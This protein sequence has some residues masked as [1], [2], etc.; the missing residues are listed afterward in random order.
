MVELKEVWAAS[1]FHSM[2][3]ETSAIFIPTF[4]FIIYAD[5]RMV[6]DLGYEDSFT[7]V[8]N[9][10]LMLQMMLELFAELSVDS[11]CT[12]V[13]LKNDIDVLGA[14]GK[15]DHPVFLVGWAG[16]ML[17]SS[18]F[19]L[20]AF[21]TVPNFVFCS[22]TDP[23]S[24]NPNAFPL[25]Q[26]VCEAIKSGGNVTDVSVLEASDAGSMSSIAN[27]STVIIGALVVFVMVSSSWWRSSAP[28]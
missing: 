14:I 9:S 25:Y 15:I 10:V 13:E 5:H 19:A 28:P 4:M 16:V 1:I 17:L 8:N 26:P 21:K 12:Y 7:P 23:C 27:M 22:S 6:F 24:C 2:L 20:N 3:A 11:I 18:A